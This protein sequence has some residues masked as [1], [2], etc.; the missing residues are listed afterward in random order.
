MPLNVAHG[1]HCRA[2]RLFIG[3]ALSDTAR[4]EIAQL[5]AQVAPTVHGWHWSSAE[6]WHITLQFLGETAAEACACVVDR[7]RTVQAAAVRVNPGGPG[8]FER[9][10]IFYLDVP[11]TAELAA[12]QR[13]VTEATAH[14]GFVAEAR[15]YRPHITLARI[16]K[17]LRT[18]EQDGSGGP[19]DPKSDRGLLRL[20][21]SLPKGPWLTPFT[22]G[23]FLL[24]RSFPD[25]GSARYEVLARFALSN[26]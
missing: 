4:E 18:K 22:V 5:V 16:Q 13:A 14:C 7:M 24:Y 21:K 15:P 25:V 3:I 20:R 8:V 19:E 11:L 10:G 1:V 23:E 26:P 17:G 2:M 6:S 9:A 12:L